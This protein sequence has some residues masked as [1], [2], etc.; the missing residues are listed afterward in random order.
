M[1]Q[2]VLVPLSKV[3][4]PKPTDRHLSLPMHQPPTLSLQKDLE[5]LNAT[6]HLQDD[7]RW[8]EYERLLQSFL[9]LT[10]SRKGFPTATG[11]EPED[12]L[13]ALFV[14]HSE[15]TANRIIKGL[16]ATIP[17][18]LFKK[19]IGLLSA[20]SPTLFQLS[21]EGHLIKEDIPIKNSNVVDLINFAVRSRKKVQLPPAWPE[22][23]E[24][25]HQSNVPRELYLPKF[26]PVKPREDP[27]KAIV[28]TPVKKESPR[29]W[30][31]APDPPRRHSVWNTVKEMQDTPNLLTAS[32][33]KLFP[34]EDNVYV[35]S[36]ETPEDA[37]H[38]E[39]VDDRRGV[40]QRHRSRQTER[41]RSRSPIKGQHKWSVMN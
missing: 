23:L 14:D 24:W 27:Q 30:M 33:M 10:H 4:R 25:I 21:P 16:E 28:D 20:L 19:A 40:S 13:I 2:H 35:T 12:P 38:S 8:K 39:N 3:P 5:K 11:Q 26:A 41:H 32:R 15:E 29:K 17:K 7:I 36:I 31:N 1:E 18:S 9:N 22:F 37:I 34:E 6:P